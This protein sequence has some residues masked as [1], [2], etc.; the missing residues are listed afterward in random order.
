M[1]LLQ[2]GQPS[3]SPKRSA[4]FFLSK[5]DKIQF[6]NLLFFSYHCNKQVASVLPRAHVLLGVCDT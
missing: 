6:L 2:T 4:V 3:V 1:L 5:M